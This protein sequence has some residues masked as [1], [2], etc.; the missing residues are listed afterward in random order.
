MRN[1]IKS[2]KLAIIAFVAIIFTSCKKNEETPM[3]TK[4]IAE[5]AA[6]TPNL[7]ILVAALTRADLATT[8]S[9]SGNYTVFAPTND[10][11]AAFLRANSFNKLEDVPIPL[12]K[13]VLLNHVIGLTVKSN[14]LTTGYVKTLA[15]GGA[16]TTNSLSMFINL[17]GG[18][19]TINGGLSNGGAVV[20]TAD[21]MATNG[22]IHVVNG[23]IGLPTFVNHAAA[24]PNFTTLVAALKFNPASSFITTL[25]GTSSSP[26]TVFAPT[27][28]AFGIFL[29][30]N[31]FANLA[32]IPAALLETTLKYHV[33]TG[34]NVLAVSL[35]N[36]QVVN[37]FAGQS[38]TIMLTGGAKI[39]DAKDNVSNIIATDVQCANGVI[40]AIDKVL[41]TR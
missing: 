2:R 3:P 14:E 10:A 41:L 28:T 20:S 26:F 24:N 7:S 19:V 25:S 39:K 9:A 34:A 40:H 33:V 37:T 16:S 35:T 38:F 8:L 30:A 21:I 27:N 31:N 15:M 22:V 5:I 12:L 32:A 18:G 36:N 13:T 4:S 1:L 17:A 11:F 6:S 29:A 23:V